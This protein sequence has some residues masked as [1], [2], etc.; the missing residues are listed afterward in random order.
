MPLSCGWNHRNRK[1]VK[2][3]GAA[4]GNLGLMTVRAR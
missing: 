2:V 4:D 3:I 1:L